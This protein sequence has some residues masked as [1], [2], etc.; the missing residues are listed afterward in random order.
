MFQVMTLDNTLEG[1]AGLFPG[2]YAPA[3]EALL[4][5]KGD[6]VEEL[7]LRV[8]QP[9]SWVTG[10]R[11]LYLAPE[12]LPPP[13]P[14]A[15]EELVRRAS[16]NAAYAVE[17][18][19]RRGFLSLPGGHRL[20]VCGTACLDGGT[21]RSLRSFQ[22]LNLRLARE[23]P[24]CADA[25]VSRLWASPGSTLIIGPP[26][27][28]KTT[29]LRDL[30]R[31]CSDRWGQRVG[32]VDERG[33]LAACRAGQA[34]LQVGRRTDVL[35]LCPKEQGIELLLRA[36]APQ[37]IATDEISAAADVR[38]MVRASYCGVRFFATAHAA[39]REDLQRRPVYRGLLREAVFENLA[40]ICP[41][42]SIRFE[43]M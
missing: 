1:L 5:E 21:L 4:R 36:M 41:D 40:L 11:E 31:Q 38:A 30:V 12:R 20:G 6:R 29:V 10:G 13:S 43:R 26:G 28:G 7:R 3:V 25:L 27:S 34:Q 16:G 24:G 33:E 42:R 37:W 22:A 35:S 23:R 8:G 39:D 9:V 2:E 19:L 17:D 32:L 14:G 18:Q 15:L